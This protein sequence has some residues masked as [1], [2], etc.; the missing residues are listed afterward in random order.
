MTSR[1]DI[2]NRV[3]SQSNTKLNT[4]SSK[5]LN[6]D[7]ENVSSK[8]IHKSQSRAKTNPNIEMDTDEQ[9]MS[10]MNERPK[11]SLS[12][13]KNTIQPESSNDVDNQSE[14]DDVYP[15]EIVMS[16]APVP[17]PRL[18][19]ENIGD[20]DIIEVANTYGK[21]IRTLCL[22]MYRCTIVILAALVV[23]AL[24]SIVNAINTRS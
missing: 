17:P 12:F 22:S 4:P 14:D 3:R 15:N 2:K 24:F 8:T 11:N 6:Q 5:I 21:T 7:T 23:I 1:S 13:F 9:Q 10:N 19:D 16:E 20:K 18:D